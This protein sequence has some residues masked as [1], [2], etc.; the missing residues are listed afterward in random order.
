VN[1]DRV[2][3]KALAIIESPTWGIGHRGTVTITVADEITISGAVKT[4]KPSFT[5]TGIFVTSYP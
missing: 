1:G 5:P 4:N 2:S 3:L